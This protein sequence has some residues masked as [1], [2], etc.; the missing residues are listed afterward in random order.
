MVHDSHSTIAVIPARGGSKRLPRKA[1]ITFR[2]AP[3]I[4]HTIRAAQEASCFDAILVSSDDEEILDVSAAAGAMPYLRPAEL[5]EDDVPTVP[6]LLDVLDAEA[7][8]GRS[9]DILA[10]LYATAPLRTADDIAGVM[11]LLDP[12]VCNFAMAVCAADRQVHQALRVGTDGQLVPVWPELLNLNSQDAP[13][14][15][16]GNGTTY[17]ASVPA[18]QE[19]KSMYGPGLRGYE[20][21]RSRSVDLDTEEDLALLQYYAGLDTLP[22]G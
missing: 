8:L 6:V 7:R 22:R 5:A 17:A 13:R 4:V 12:G 18:L 16:F 14:Y 9:W 3:M 11:S 1:L 10:C 2:N 19:H 15:L 21:P 20:M